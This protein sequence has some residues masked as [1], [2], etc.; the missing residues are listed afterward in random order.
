LSSRRSPHFGERLSTGNL[1]AFIGLTTGGTSIGFPLAWINQGVGVPV[2]AGRF[3]VS[4]PL[5]TR[6]YADGGTAINVSAISGSGDSFSVTL[7]GHLIT[8][9]V[10]A[11]CALR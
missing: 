6:Y 3:L 9:D 10:S 5:A 2:F 11:G 4:G 8:C 1:S 7:S